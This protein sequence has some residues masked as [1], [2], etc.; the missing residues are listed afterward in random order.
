VVVFDG[1][2]VVEPDAPTLPTPTIAPLVALALVQL[3][4]ALLP[5]VI[6]DVLSMSL[7]VGVVAAKTIV[8]GAKR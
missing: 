5:A 8:V 2:T 7:H 1:C 6:L 4:V 3:S